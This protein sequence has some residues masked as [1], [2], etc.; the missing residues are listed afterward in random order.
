MSA[1]SENRYRASSFAAARKHNQ[2]IADQEA[3]RRLPRS[4]TYRLEALT[5]VWARGMVYSNTRILMDGIT[6][7]SVAFEW[8]ARY[9][10]QMPNTLVTIVAY[11]SRPDS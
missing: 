5:K 6:S 2:R 8:K 7:A 4:T 11:A 1:R 9:A 10:R 3:M